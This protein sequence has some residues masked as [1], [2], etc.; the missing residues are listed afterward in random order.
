VAAKYDFSVIGTSGLAHQG[1]RIDT[2][3]NQHLR[4]NRGPLLYREMS[5]NDGVIGAILH[6]VKT[7]LK[8]TPWTVQPAFENDQESLDWADF[9]ESCRQDMSHTWSDFISEILSM[10][11]YGWSYF[12]IC[13]KRRGGMTGKETS[14]SKYDDSYIGWRKIS[15]R[16]QNTLHRWELDRES[17]IQ[18]MWQV[19]PSDGWG[20]GGLNNDPVLIPIERSLLFRTEV[21]GN[22]P[23]GRSLLRN[24]VRPYLYCKRMQEIEAVGTERDLVGYPVF[25][26]PLS[27]FTSTDAD[28]VSMVA[29]LQQALCDLRRDAREGAVIPCEIDSDA[30]PTGFK[31]RLLNSGGARAHDT[32]KIIRR[33]ESRMAMPLL[34]EFI[35]LG[36]DKVGSFSMHASKQDVFATSLR[37]LNNSIADTINRYAVTRLC[38]ING[39]PADKIPTLVPGD[40]AAPALTDMA[41][42]VQAMCNA[43]VVVPDKALDRWARQLA[44]MPEAEVEPLPGTAAQQD[45]SGMDET[46]QQTEGDEA[47][48]E[49]AAA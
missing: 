1:G 26:V 43:G 39:C 12:E 10:V 21:T 49:E 42:F 32:D 4:G 48:A 31:L 20:L 17:G 28:N 24:S 37:A 18:G 34:C 45:G 15:I 14:N 46:S 27:M 30:K 11:V 41:A 23:Q 7:F 8:Q 16:P 13:Y 29:Q 36:T 35:L 47:F 9:V 2:E 44:G 25:E 38:A 3:L 6:L 19:A 5:E 40:V 33:D 22:N